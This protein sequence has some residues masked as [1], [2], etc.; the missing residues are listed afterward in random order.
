VSIKFLISNITAGIVI[1]KGGASIRKLNEVS[2]TVIAISNGKDCYPNT[3]SRIVQINGLESDVCLAQHMIWEVI[4]LETQSAPSEKTAWMPGSEASHSYDH[5]VVEGQITIPANAA[6]AVLG[7]GGATMRSISSECSVTIAMSNKEDAESTE[8]RIL[9]ISGEL[10]MCAR[11]V[12]LI[13]KKMCE[14]GESVDFTYK[15]G[16]YPSGKHHFV[17]EPAAREASARVQYVPASGF[18]KDYRQV[19]TFSSGGGGAFGAP[20]GKAGLN[21]GLGTLDTPGDFG[22]AGAAAMLSS[23]STIT[24]AV[25]DA[26]VGSI[27]GPKGATIHEIMSLSGGA[28]VSVS[29]RGEFVE[30]TTNRVVTITGSPSSTQTAC[31][32]VQQVLAR[33]AAGE[34]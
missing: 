22:A 12:T 3:A 14:E 25:A 20:Y 6:G 27:L 1:G 26:L 34:L 24:L 18:V 7:K 19:A 21:Y 15:S 29:P 23:T 2:G 5:V 30:G 11:C 4:G 31:R 10:S 13:I 16:Q 9:A 28:K 17:E 32:I 33:N 8:E